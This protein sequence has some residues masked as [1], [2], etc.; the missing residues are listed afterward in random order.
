[1]SRPRILFVCHR[2]PY[3]PKRGGKIRPFNILRHLQQRAAVTVASLVRSAEEEAEAQGI[4][5]YCEDF[6]LARIGPGA[7][8]GR[9][10]LRLPTPVPSSLGN[11]YSPVLARRIL[12]RARETAF[13]LAF[14]HCSSAAQYVLP[15]S[16]LPKVLDFGDMDSEKWSDYAGWRAFPLSLGYW[17]EGRKLRREEARLAAGV[18]LATCTTAAELA[19]LQALGTARAT[20]WFPNGVD[21]EFFSPGDGYDEHTICFA[22]RMDYYPNQQA[23]HWLVREILPLIRRVRPQTRLLIVGAEPPAAIR[24]YAEEP[25]I[26]VTG[27][28]PDVRPF[29]RSAAVSVAPLRIARGTQNKILEAA[30]MG[31]PVVTT[32][33][34][35]GGVDMRPGEEL[36]VADS[37]TDF[38]AAVLELLTDRERR[39]ELASAARARVLSH[40]DWHASMRKLDTLLDREFPGLLPAAPATQ[41]D[42]ERVS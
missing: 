24:Q 10:L 5:A 37:A 34:A 36:L 25:L 27:T 13:D 6:L 22:G 7:A 15:L 33:R 30:A 29:V 14:V 3:P 2:F 17:L 21:A 12:E 8:L 40:H 42:L 26:E 11:F 39:R 19:S 41:T 38:A 16:G 9:M 28:V 31:V 1:M 35:A 4:A 32:G 23:V 20:G 18:E